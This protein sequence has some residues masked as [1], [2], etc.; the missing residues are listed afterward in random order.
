MLLKT[1]ILI[2]VVAVFA[3]VIL[4]MSIFVQTSEKALENLKDMEIQSIGFAQIPNGTY[5]GSY[6]VFPIKVR[7][8]VTVESGRVTDLAL[9]E[10]R[11]GKGNAAEQILGE[12][13]KAQ[14][15]KV[16]TISSATYSSKVILKAVEQAL[17]NIQK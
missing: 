15:L 14:S 4:G 17:T 9:L 3:V 1:K 11:N 10:H 13:M 5:L 6:S 16:D 7:V 12:I 2:I 8:S